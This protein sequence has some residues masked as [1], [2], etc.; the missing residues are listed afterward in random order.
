MYELYKNIKTRKDF[1]DQWEPEKLEQM[2]ASVKDTVYEKYVVK[3][4]V[5]QRDN[6][7]CQ[8]ENCPF[9]KNEPE[10]EQ[11]TMHHIRFQKNGGENKERNCITLCH[12]SHK[13]FHRG[14]NDLSFPDTDKLPSHIRGH[15]FKVTFEEGIDWKQIKKSMRSLRR[16]LHDESGFRITWEEVAVLIRFLMIPYYEMEDLDDD[17]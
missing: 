5:F 14:K 6:F 15:T 7:T 11:L 8:N 10:H 13:S 3:C 12:S 2:S 16:Q 1:F 17:V 9:C 4:N